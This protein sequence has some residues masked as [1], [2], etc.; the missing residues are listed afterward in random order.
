MNTLL[1]QRVIGIRHCLRIFK[2]AGLINNSILYPSDAVK[3]LAQNDRRSKSAVRFRKA[4]SDATIATIIKS[5]AETYGVPT[6]SI[7][8][9]HPSGRKVRTDASVGTLRKQWHNIS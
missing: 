9:E 7:K 6:E 4:R 5:I 2:D 3:V 8:F 1:K